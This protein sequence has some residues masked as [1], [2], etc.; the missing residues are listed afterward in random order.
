MNLSTPIL[1]KLN[2]VNQ[3][4]NYSASIHIQVDPQA[5][6]NIYDSLN[7]ELY[8]Q[9]TIRQASQVEQHLYEYILSNKS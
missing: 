8:I 9:I 2:P 3:I 7:T 4:G 1:T 6:T 5:N